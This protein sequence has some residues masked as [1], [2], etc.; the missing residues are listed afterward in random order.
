MK[1]KEKK[2]DFSQARRGA[3]VPPAPGKTRITIRLDNEVLEWFRQKVHAA[4]GGN[5]QTLINQA[6][7]EYFQSREG[8][9]AETLGRV[10]KEELAGAESKL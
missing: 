7:R 6:R 5:Y 2:Y 3:V 1:E 4:G 8:I 9:L 10:I